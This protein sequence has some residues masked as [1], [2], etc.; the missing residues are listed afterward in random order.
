MTVLQIANELQFV[1]V[2]TFWLVVVYWLLP[3][4]RVDSFRQKMFCVRD[5]LFDFAAK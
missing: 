2:L 4:Y 3:T 5:E 1:V